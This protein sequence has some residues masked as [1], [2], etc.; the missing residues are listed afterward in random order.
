VFPDFRKGIAL[1]EGSYD[2]SAFPS[3]KGSVTMKVAMQYWWND[4]DRWKRVALGERLVAVLLTAQKNS[5][6]LTRFLTFDMRRRLLT[7]WA[8]SRRLKTEY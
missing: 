4:T 6:M 3:H 1:F 5:Q 7:T 2:S 8:M